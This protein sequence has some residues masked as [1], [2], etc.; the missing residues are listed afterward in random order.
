MLGDVVVVH[1]R[2]PSSTC[3]HV[4]LDKIWTLSAGEMTRARARVTSSD[5]A[6]LVTAPLLRDR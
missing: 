2:E 3:V 4:S 1:K 6:P 5:Q